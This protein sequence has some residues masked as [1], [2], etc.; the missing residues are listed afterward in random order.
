MLKYMLDGGPLMWP[1]LIQS[2]VALAVFFERQRVFRLAAA[3]TTVMRKMI[4]QLIAA[5]KTEDAVRL[6]EE[7]KGPVAAI[8]LVG[9]TRYA[10]LKKS[11]RAQAEIEAS[12]S[13]CMQDYA[14]HVINALEKRVGLLLAI[15][16]T[17]PLLGMTGTVTGMIKAFGAMAGAG[18]LS[19]GLVAAGIAEALIT[20][21]AGLLIAVPTVVA[22][23]V[24][25]NKVEQHTL[26]IED[27]ASEM[28]NF[29]HLQSVKT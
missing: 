16:S 21:A 5:D 24:M 11:G 3:D 22:Y 18:A 13:Q 14:P 26:I 25:V 23:N 6:C 12:V 19:G 10:K 7:T 8:L 29:I 9:L 20:T 2:I 4:Y 15:A 27:A 1:M 28:I 17:A